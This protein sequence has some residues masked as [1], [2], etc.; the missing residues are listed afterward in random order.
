MRS[1]RVKALL[2]RERFLAFLED[3]TTRGAKRFSDYLE[4]NVLPWFSWIEETYDLPGFHAWDATAALYLTDPQLF[5]SREVL[6]CSNLDD[7][8]KGFLRF[9]SANTQTAEKSG[10][11][12]GKVWR[13][14]IPTRIL[15]L[16]VY[17]QTLFNCWY[18]TGTAWPE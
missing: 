17:W 7:L 6:L 3:S 16:P 14:D 12:D 11:Q 10:D 13:I 18:N 1:M 8:K 15:D 5:E 2:T 4:E 9:D